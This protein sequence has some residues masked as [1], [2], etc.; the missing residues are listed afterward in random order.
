MVANTLEIVGVKV[1]CWMWWMWSST[2]VERW[3]DDVCYERV[4]NVEMCRLISC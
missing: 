3:V 4:A 2:R 1:K